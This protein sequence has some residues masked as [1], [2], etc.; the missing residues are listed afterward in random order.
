MPSVLEEYTRL[1]CLTTIDFVHS[2][3]VFD[4]SYDILKLHVVGVIMPDSTF[5]QMALKFIEGCLIASVKLY[6]KRIERQTRGPLSFYRRL[7]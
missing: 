4:E 5:T 2:E 6:P 1:I 3:F 7:E